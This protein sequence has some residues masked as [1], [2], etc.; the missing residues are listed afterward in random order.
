MCEKNSTDDI[1]S[2]FCV[3]DYESMAA[4]KGIGVVSML[5]LLVLLVEPPYPWAQRWGIPG[6]SVPL[7]HHPPQCLF[8]TDLLS[9][10]LRRS[11]FCEEIKIWCLFQIH[12][13]PSFQIN[14]SNSVVKKEFCVSWR[15]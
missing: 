9:F 1:L 4:A 5:Y 6:Q 11:L 7:S 3:R 8:F 10:L 15:C 2:N 14:L 13:R 12:S